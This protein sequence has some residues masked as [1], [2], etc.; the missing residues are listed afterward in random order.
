MRA[1]LILDAAAAW[2]TF[3]EDDLAT[4]ADRAVATA[5]HV[6]LE[7]AGFDHWEADAALSVAFLDDTRVARLNQDFRNKPEPTNVLSWP[8][9]EGETPE[10]IM[11]QGQAD[12]PAVYWGDLALAGETV[13]RETLEQEKAPDAHLSHLIIHGVLHLL[14]FDYI[15]EEQAELM[16]GLERL[17]MRDL[18]YPD[19]YGE[20]AE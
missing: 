2:P 8:S 6:G 12:G 1:E 16:E 13:H 11:E 9:F 15:E 19:P 14:G 10:D 4:L 18:G 3:S 7:S 17:A 5:F 20:S